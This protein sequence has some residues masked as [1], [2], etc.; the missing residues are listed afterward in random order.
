[1]WLISQNPQR[2]VPN[3]IYLLNQ[4]SARNFATLRLH[5]HMAAYHL[6]FGGRERATENVSKSGIVLAREVRFLSLKSVHLM[7][8]KV[9]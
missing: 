2:V 9:R 1:M 6:R 8:R 5:R 4:L 7:S 3:P